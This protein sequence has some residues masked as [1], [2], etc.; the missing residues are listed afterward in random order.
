MPLQI[1]GCG[2]ALVTPFRRDGTVDDDALRR[3]LRRFG[4]RLHIGHRRHR[5]E[6]KV[7]EVITGRRHPARRWVVERTNSW[8]NRF[9]ALKLRWEKKPE[10][11]LGLVQFACALIVFRFLG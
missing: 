10:N 3:G 9:R 6:P 2:T 1:R 5:G 11:Y 7:E 8:H 4:Y